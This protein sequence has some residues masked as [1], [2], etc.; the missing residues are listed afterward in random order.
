ML[1]VQHSRDPVALLRRL[2]MFGVVT[3]AGLLA[4]GCAR[5]G[6]GEATLKIANPFRD[7][8]GPTD[9]RLHLVA[10]GVDGCSD[11]DWSVGDVT[12]TETPERVIVGAE[13]RT[14]GGGPFCEVRQIEQSFAVTL[15][16]PLGQRVI[17]DHRVGAVIWSPAKRNKFVRA[18]RVDPS[19]A[20]ALLR[21][22]FGA[23]RAVQCSGGR[24]K[25]FGCSV[26]SPSRERSVTV[27]VFIRPGG[28]LKPMAGEKLPPDLRTCEG[29]PGHSGHFKIC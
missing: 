13:I 24:G 8:P 19:D 3:A 2:L 23:G 11:S 20:E 16:Q 18:Q 1:S 21:S 26:W 28:E 25:Y 15:R 6:G 14:E 29:A 27:Y 9:T 5:D 7:A 12:V 22:K 4:S 17:I 10:G